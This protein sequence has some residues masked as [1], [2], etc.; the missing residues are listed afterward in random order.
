MV[1]RRPYQILPLGLL[2]GFLLVSPAIAQDNLA[3]L[4][5]RFGQENDPVRKARAFPPLG[6][7][8]INVLR[9]QVRREDYQQGLKILERYRDEARIVF[10]GLKK[11]RI[12]AE[13]KSNGFRQL[14][15]HLRRTVRQLTE[16]ITTVLFEEREPFEAIRK[17]IDQ[18]DRELINMLFPRQPG[19]KIEK[20]A[21]GGRMQ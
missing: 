17:E 15:I 6:E 9:E 5:L 2:C 16:I 10:G 13:K 18:M 7:A 20:P 4:E 8:R 19:A 3:K 21:K 11:S 14:Q 1:R 12:D